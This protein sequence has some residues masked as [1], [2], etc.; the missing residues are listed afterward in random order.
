MFSRLK[1]P[2]KNLAVGE[3]CTIYRGLADRAKRYVHVY[4]S[5]SGKRMKCKTNPDG[6]LTVTR[7]PEK[8]TKGVRVTAEELAILGQVFPTKTQLK[9]FCR[10]G[11]GPYTVFRTEDGGAIFEPKDV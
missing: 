5:Q 1:W 6:S 10:V 2:F 11:A 3:S 9:A 4:A 8:G 7:I